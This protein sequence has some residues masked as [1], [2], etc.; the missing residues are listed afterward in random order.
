MDK[1]L[2]LTLLLAV[3]FFSNCSNDSSNYYKTDTVED[4]MDTTD[5]GEQEEIVIVTGPKGQTL[6]PS[7]GGGIT[8]SSQFHLT[9]SIG[10]PQ[11][12]GKTSGALYTIHMGVGEILPNITH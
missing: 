7:S 1:R 2:L 11:P 9:L 4:N 5:T 6:F 12:S 10:P 8:T 3:L